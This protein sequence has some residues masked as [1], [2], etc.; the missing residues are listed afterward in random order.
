MSLHLD[1]DVAAGYFVNMASPYENVLVRHEAAHEE[2]KQHRE[3][4][5]RLEREIQELTVAMRVLRRIYD[6]DGPP[7]ED[8][9]ANLEASVAVQRKPPG[10]PAMP[11]MIVAAIKDGKARGHAGLRPRDMVDFIA[12]EFWPEVQ[13][14][15][16]GPIAARML[17]DG[18]LSK[19][20][21]TGLYGLPQDEAP[22]VTAA[23]ASEH[24]FGAG[25]VDLE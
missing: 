24:D 4:L 23:E 22:A 9:K 5:S 8:E 6:G 17:K 2:V 13:F 16:V 7:D 14:T 11:D 12:R 10:L 21:E 15:S 20:A 25:N 18:R 3:A 19:N 1:A